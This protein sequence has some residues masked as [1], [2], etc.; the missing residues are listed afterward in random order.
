MCGIAEWSIAAYGIASTECVLNRDT[1]EVEAAGA[2]D[3]VFHSSAKP[4]S[5]VQSVSFVESAG[6]VLLLGHAYM[7]LSPAQYW[8]SEHVLQ[9]MDSANQ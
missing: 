9:S 6:A 5:H 1:C 4:L 7:K 2:I 3:N 8:F